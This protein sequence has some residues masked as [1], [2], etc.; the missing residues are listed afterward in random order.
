MTVHRPVLQRQAILASAAVALISMLGACSSSSGGTGANNAPSG[1]AAGTPVRGGTLTVARTADIFTFDPY[2]TQDDRSIF[3]ELEIYDRLVKLGPDGKSVQPELA[4]AWTVAK[5]GKS[6]TF[7]L[8]SGVKFSDG[9]PLTADDVVYSLTRDADQ[10]GSWGFLFTPISK[11]SKVSEQQIRIDLSQPFAPLLPALSTFAASIYSKANAVK[12]GKAAGEHPLGTGAFAL[13]TWQKGTALTLKRND[14]YWQQGKPY[15]DKVVFKVVGDD[16]ARTL[17]L[18]SGEVDVADALAPD[19]VGGL[20][21]KGLKVTTVNGSA[22]TW[23]IFNEAKK[24]LD[25]PKVRLALSYAMDRATVAK[26]VYFGNANPAKSILPGSSLYYSADQQPAV[27]D[28]AKAKQLLSESSAPNGFDLPMTIPSGDQASLVT[29]QLWQ[30]SLQKIGVKL[31]INQLEATT[32]QDE[33]NTEKYSARI[34]PWTNDTPDPDELMGV[35]MDY[36]PQNGLHT[37][38]KNEQSRTLVTQA[39]GELDPVKRAAMYAQLEL[40]ANQQQPFIPIVEVPRLFASTT[41][42]QG[43]VPNS[44]GKYAFADVW[45]TK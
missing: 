18:Q 10:K 29:A 35:A 15:L 40:I 14:N 16:N 28:L 4:T 39:R 12:F 19:Q 27:F 2:S 34:S 3:T 5:D 36:K 17:Q 22:V 6:A 45:K 23:V 31:K 41:A 38:F 42:V 9:T 26:N 30:A 44:Q 7:D 32:A 21:D 24:P 43:F 13:E 37:G 11:V 1:A 33:Y 20:K 8:R 25:D